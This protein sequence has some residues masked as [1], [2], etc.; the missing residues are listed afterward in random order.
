MDQQISEWVAMLEAEF[1][2]PN[3]FLWKVR[4]G[5]FDAEGG[6]RFIS[7][8]SEIRFPEDRPLDRRLVSIIWF[9]PLFLTWQKESLAARGGD[10]E[11]LE[12]VISRVT[13]L[14]IE[15]LGVP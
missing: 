9:L 8:L 12:R 10:A 1:G 2:E 13:D 5:V 11:R 3:G 7:V 4:Y 15:L 6:E 14:V